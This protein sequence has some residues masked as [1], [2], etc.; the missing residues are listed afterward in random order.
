L[1]GKESYYRISDLDRSGN[2]MNWRCNERVK[3]EDGRLEFGRDY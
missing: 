1:I 2:A 3:K